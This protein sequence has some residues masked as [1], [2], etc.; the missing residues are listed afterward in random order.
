MSKVL[1]TGISLFL[2]IKLPQGQEDQAQKKV[3]FVWV[4]TLFLHGAA[5]LPVTDGE[6]PW[7]PEQKTELE[8]FCPVF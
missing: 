2:V 7:G 8:A 6:L 3:L 1:V 5:V 4:S